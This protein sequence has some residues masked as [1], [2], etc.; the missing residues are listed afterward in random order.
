[1][2]VPIPIQDPIARP[3]RENLSEGQKDSAEGTI[4]LPWIQYFQNQ[5]DT[6]SQ[7]PTKV[8]TPVSLEAQSAAIGNTAIPTD[9]LASGLYRVSYSA[10]VTQ[11]ATTSSSLTVTITWTAGGITQS[12]SGAAMTGNTTA[13]FQSGTYLIDI[14]AASPVS[15]STSYASNAAA[16]MEYTL[17]VVLEEIAT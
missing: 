5:T 15:Y 14:D 8:T 9:S 11:A 4:T 16:E 6:F 12:Q 3:K 10:R 7:A 2:S 1:M 13:T 17:S